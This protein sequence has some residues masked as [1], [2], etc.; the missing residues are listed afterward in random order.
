[1]LKAC[2]LSKVASLEFCDAWNLYKEAFP[3]AERRPLRC[4]A[5]AM[6]QAS[7]FHCYSFYSEH[8]F[9]GL[10]F[11]WKLSTCIYV[12]HLAVAP[13]M[14]GQGIGRE[15]LQH[16]HGRGVPVFL[17]IEPVKDCATERRL[18]FYTALGYQTSEHV[19][20]Q[21]PFHHHDEPLRL[22][23]LS[24]PEPADAA[25]IAE[26]EKDFLSY[27]MQYRQTHAL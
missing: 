3:I 12:E 17:E 16:V 15:I 10:L 24:Y 20:Y 8:T 7:A 26:F 18:R 13:F 2:K 9:V 6:Q 11:Y 4:H 25:L 5:A 21:L 23:L 27:P 22:Q 19:H 1:M 14:R